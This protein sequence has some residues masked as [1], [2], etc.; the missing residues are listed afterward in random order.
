MTIFVLVVCV[1]DYRKG[2]DGLLLTGYVYLSDI[3]V[4]FQ[5]WFEH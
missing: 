1:E 3:R 5:E 4:C 2:V